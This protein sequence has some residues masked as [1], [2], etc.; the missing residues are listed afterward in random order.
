MS[1]FSCFSLLKLGS[2]VACATGDLFLSS[3]GTETRRTKKGGGPVAA[4]PPS[5]DL[6]VMICRL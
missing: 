4:T 2:P 6:S 5:Y 1:S 3:D